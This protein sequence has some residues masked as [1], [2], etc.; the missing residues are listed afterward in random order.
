MVVT[1][2]VWN[3]HLIDGY[4]TNGKATSQRRK[5]CDPL[6]FMHAQLLANNFEVAQKELHLP[7]CR[8][9]VIF[10]SHSHFGSESDFVNAPSFVI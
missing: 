7:H 3:Q 1:S 5:I 8:C 6:A 10:E 4:C 2:T 9:R